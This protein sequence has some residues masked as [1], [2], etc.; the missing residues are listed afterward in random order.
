M[1]HHPLQLVESHMFTKMPKMRL[2]LFI[3]TQVQTCH[4][5]TA[6]GSATMHRKIG[7][8]NPILL[9]TC[10][11]LHLKVVHKESGI[12][13]AM[14]ICYL[15]SPKKAKL[16]LKM[17]HISN[18][19]LLPRSFATEG[20][21]LPGALLLDYVPPEEPPSTPLGNALRIR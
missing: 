6:A 14:V 19:L 20:E 3:A 5:G 16:H 9:G 4:L 8:L 10:R 2:T 15:D 12:S 21:C 7:L 18:K 1:T 13:V 11:R 17:V